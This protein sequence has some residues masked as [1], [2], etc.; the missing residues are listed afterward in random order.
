MRYETTLPKWQWPEAYSGKSWEGW[1][2]APCSINRD[3]TPLE[4]S[5]WQA[6][7]EDIPESDT[8]RIVREGHFLCGWVEWLAIRMDDEQALRRADDIARALEDYPVL[9]E[10]K[11]SSMEFDAYLEAWESWGEREYRDKLRGLEIEGLDEEEIDAALDIMDLDTVLID[12]R[13]KVSWEFQ[14]N[15]SEVLINIDELVE[16]TDQETLCRLVTNAC[17]HARTTLDIRKLCEHLGVS[18]ETTKDAVS[19]RMTLV[20]Q[21]MEV[22]RNRKASK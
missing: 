15:G 18:D 20:S 5:N 17:T 6:M 14:V 4:L 10:E 11:L 1:H 8:V 22:E 7:C 21:I 19:K 2:I 3:S 13:G 16:H 12:A 9:D